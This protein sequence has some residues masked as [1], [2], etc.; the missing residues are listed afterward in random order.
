MPDYKKE[1]GTTRVGDALRWLVK[2]GK[3]VAPEI[4]KI[5]GNVTGIEALELLADKISTNKTLSETDKQI[6]L[7]ELRFDMIEMQE[8]TKRWQ[9]DMQSDS[10]LSKNIR[11]LSLAF[12]TA[13]LFLY[14][15]LDSCLQGFK[16]AKE[17]INLLSSLLLLVY[18]GYFGARSMEKISKYW[19]Q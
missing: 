12:L 3:E 11:P 1:N 10:W 13:S 16:I 7:E 5:A 15:I 8:T 19:K 9:Y 4:L 2:Q 14:I 18:G 17:W 6:L